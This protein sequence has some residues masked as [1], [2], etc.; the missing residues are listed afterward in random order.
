MKNDYIK[1]KKCSVCRGTGCSPCPMVKKKS[2]KLTRTGQ[3]A[4]C[5]GTGFRGRIIVE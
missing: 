1:Y 2:T 3:C 5:H 4:Y